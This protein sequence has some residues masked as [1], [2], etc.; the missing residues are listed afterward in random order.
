[1]AA[2]LKHIHMLTAI[3]SILG[4]VLRGFWAWRM[5]RMLEKKAVRIVPHVIDTILLLSAIGMLLIYR[6]NPFAFDWL[7]VKIVLLVVYIGL[8]LVTLKPW[9]DAR[10]RTVT[11]I[12][13]VA[14]FAWIYAV[15]ITRVPVPFVG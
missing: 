1:M 14:V 8:G 11:F 9:F 3:L 6:W 7:V 12:A 4:F 5:P 13:A 2:I 10:V 15:A